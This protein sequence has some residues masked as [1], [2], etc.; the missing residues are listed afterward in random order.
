MAGAGQGGGLPPQLG[1][2]F[3]QQMHSD[4]L[5]FDSLHPDHP[6]LEGE[7]SFSP[8]RAVAPRLI[9]DPAAGFE[10]PVRVTLDARSVRRASG[11]TEITTIWNQLIS[12]AGISHAGLRIFAVVQRAD[13]EQHD[14]DIMPDL[15]HDESDEDYVPDLA[16]DILSDLI[17][18][19]S[20]VDD[21]PDLA[22]PPGPAVRR[23]KAKK[24]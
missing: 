21:M 22:P 15:M 8:V 3:M 9:S 4:F 18:D 6:H 20:D 12:H 7:L 16:H 10:T 23:L 1:Y 5:H 11:P 19:E 2:H 13:R 24:N 14:S 17:S